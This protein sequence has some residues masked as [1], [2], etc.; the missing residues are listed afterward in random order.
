MDSLRMVDLKGQYLSIKDEIDEAVA[1][2]LDE[3]AFINGP[4]TRSFAEHLAQYAGCKH[5]VT[6]GN[7]TDALRISLEALRLND[8]DE[9]II[10][11]FTYAASAEAI[12]MLRLVPVMVDVDPA[13]FNLN[14]EHIQAGFSSKTRAII[15]VHLFGQC[16][17]MDEILSFAREHDLHVIEDN[18]QSLGCEYTS[19]DGS[20]RKSGTLGEIG[21]NS[22][23]PT[24]NLGC[25]GD[26]GS[27]MTN[28]D[29]LA[30]R[31]HQ[32]ANHGQQQK[33]RHEI[34][35]CNSR[36]DTIQAAVLEVKLRHLDAFIQ[37]RREAAQRYDS[38]L[39]DVEEIITPKEMLWNRHSYNQY[40]LRVKEG[41]RDALKVYLAEQGVPTMIY[42]PL[43]LNQQHAYADVSR[44]AEPLGNT[45][46]LCASVLSIPMH[47]ELTPEQQQRIS[48]RIHDFFRR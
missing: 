19:K 8:G 4:E 34:I 13:T 47:T 32:I 6:C 30:E 26:G 3:T 46:E 15:P 5:V 18:A 38:L 20:V 31:L 43:P 42:Y 7:C 28:D 22:F 35:G 12:A 29:A 44:V 40:T 48:D 23:F 17:D 10:P 14:L 37:V 39:S 25:F 45:E 9:V 33:Y 1:K 27:M 24:K 21:C 2:V 41:K 16:C 36:L 11:A